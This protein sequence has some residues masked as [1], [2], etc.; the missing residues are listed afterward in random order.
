MKRS[1]CLPLCLVL[2]AAACAAQQ[3]P[4]EKIVFVAEDS[5]SNRAR[6]VNAKDAAVIDNGRPSPIV[7]IDSAEKLP[8][9]LGILLLSSSPTFKAQQAAAVQLL[10]TL[11]PGVDLAFVTMIGSPLPRDS[12]AREMPWNTDPKA[13]IAFVRSL[14]GDESLPISTEVARLMMAADPDETY[15]RVLVEFRD[16]KV[17]A[18]VETPDARMQAIVERKKKAQLDEI[19]DYQRCRTSVYVIAADSTLWNPPEFRS[20]MSHVNP[21]TLQMADDDGRSKQD[22]IAKMTGGRYF[23]SRPRD[24]AKEIRQ[25]L[26]DLNSQFVVEFVPEP[27]PPDKPGHSLE[28]RVSGARDITYQKVFFPRF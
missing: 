8:I 22:R 23:G 27:A 1:F 12:R 19:S 7:S 21:R 14:H 26:A 9:R 28:V 6:G 24:Y 5:G 20:A 15:R 2:A 17:D 16:P 18:I 4:T 10:E 11:R 13:L 25:I 3:Q